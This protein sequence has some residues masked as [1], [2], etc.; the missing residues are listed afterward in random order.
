MYFWLFHCS[1]GLSGFSLSLLHG[2]PIFKMSFFKP[3][4]S[5]WKKI[6]RI[7][8]NEHVLYRK[9]SR[10]F[11]SC[12]LTNRALQMNYVYEQNKEGYL[13]KVVFLCSLITFNFGY[14]SSNNKWTKYLPILLPTWKF[15][16]PSLALWNNELSKYKRNS[17]AMQLFLQVFIPGLS[18]SWIS[19]SINIITISLWLKLI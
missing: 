5:Q 16:L 9:V 4:C 8:R 19:V 3:V 7:V 12:F 11:Y 18:Y 2:N 15:S 6:G 13:E 14:T 1:T 17:S 10:I